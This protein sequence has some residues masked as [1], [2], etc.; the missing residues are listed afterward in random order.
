MEYQI[1]ILK[2]YLALFI[3]GNLS[4]DQ[5]IKMIKQDAQLDPDT[6]K[7]LLSFNNK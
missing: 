6:I 7:F 1:T 2:D 4:N 5:I 3:T